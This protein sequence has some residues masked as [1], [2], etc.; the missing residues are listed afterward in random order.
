MIIKKY[1]SVYD[2]NSFLIVLFIFIN[3]LTLPINNTIN[4]SLAFW[5]LLIG[6]FIYSIYKNKI[7]NFKLILLSLIFIIFFLF[8]M[9]I[10]D[11]KIDI[12]NML[13]MFI[14]YGI[15]SLYF[16]S[17]IKDYSSLIVYWNIIS[18]IAFFI[19]NIYISDFKENNQYMTFGIYMTYSFIGFALYYYQKS[20]RFIDVMFMMISLVQIFIHGNRSSIIICIVVLIYLEILNIKSNKNLKITF[21]ISSLLLILFFS[22]QIIYFVIEKMQKI[23]EIL[24]I[25]S[26]SITKISNAMGKGID[27]IISESSG[28]DVI[29]EYAKNIIVESNF[30]PHPL[31]YFKYSTNNLIPYPHNLFLEILIDF[32]IVGLIIFIIIVLFLLVKCLNI[33]D[34]KDFISISGVCAIYSIGRLMFS[35]SYWTEPFFWI[36]IGII[37]FANVEKI[38]IKENRV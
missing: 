14:R 16:C 1:H 17:L 22:K 4:N 6:L 37:Y 5:I 25:N 20:K 21:K 13:F 7:V 12:L 2:R 31:N 18:Y 23:L 3:V 15:L 19:C 24:N 10:V 9:I 28:R 26:Y 35:D 32:G 8:N 29:Y 27:G 30:M 34:E 33:Y 38:L 11:Y 36:T